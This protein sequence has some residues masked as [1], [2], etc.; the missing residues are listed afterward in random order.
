MLES[1]NHDWLTGII[2]IDNPEPVLCP[3]NG[4]IQTFEL[5][6]LESK[7]SDALKADAVTDLMDKRCILR[8]GQFILALVCQ[9][10]PEIV[11]CRVPKEVV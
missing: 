8:L 7:S 11:E 5:Q 2:I 3:S 4:N 1:T 10:L 9:I 6:R